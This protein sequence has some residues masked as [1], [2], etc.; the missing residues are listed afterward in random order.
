MDHYL[1]F[2][3]LYLKDCVGA[4]DGTHMSSVIPQ[5]KQLPYRSGRKGEC[6]RNV[7]AACDFD[8]QFTFIYAGWKGTAND[9]QIMADAMYNPKWNFPPAPPGECHIKAHPFSCLCHVYFY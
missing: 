2:M 3:F 1:F 4:I 9:S 6:T 8:M 5:D 7:M